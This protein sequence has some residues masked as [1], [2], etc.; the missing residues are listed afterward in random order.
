[1]SY[2]TSRATYKENC[3]LGQLKNIKKWSVKWKLN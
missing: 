3:M 2:Q 1:M